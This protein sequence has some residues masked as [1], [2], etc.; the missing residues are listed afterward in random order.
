MKLEFDALQKA[1]KRVENDIKSISHKRQRFSTSQEPEATNAKTVVSKRI[2]PRHNSS[3]QPLRDPSQFR[4][5]SDSAITFSM[6]N[7]EAFKA[8]RDERLLS[9]VKKDVKCPDYEQRFLNMLE[10]NDSG[11]H[12]NVNNSSSSKNKKRNVPNIRQLRCE[13]RFIS[14]HRI[15]VGEIACSICNGG[16]GEGAGMPMENVNRS[17]HAFDSQMVHGAVDYSWNLAKLD[18]E[19]RSKCGVAEDGRVKSNLM[20]RFGMA[21]PVLPRE[22]NKRETNDGSMPLKAEDA[23]PNKASGMAIGALNCSERDEILTSHNQT[24]STLRLDGMSDDRID[25]YWRKISI[26]NICRD[27]EIFFQKGCFITK[28]YRK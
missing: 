16:I 26:P 23:I 20:T 24:I 9:Q 27:G 11:K 7:M 13:Q 1:K 28:L 5:H 15:S 2:L 4:A 19:T 3:P 17:G 18:Q 6:R 14:D 25:E 12:N 22:K 8:S 10:A 21:T